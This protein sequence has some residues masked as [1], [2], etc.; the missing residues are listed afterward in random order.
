MDVQLE[1]ECSSRVAYNTHR[2]N[3]MDENEKQKH[4]QDHIDLARFLAPF[5][6]ALI[7]NRFCNLETVVVDTTKKEPSAVLINTNA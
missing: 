2:T 7:L 5:P 4:R 3:S 6:N 1:R